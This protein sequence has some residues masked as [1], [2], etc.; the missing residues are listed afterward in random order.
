MIVRQVNIG[1]VL[2]RDPN[3]IKIRVQLADALSWEKKYDE[4]V[5]EYKKIFRVRSREY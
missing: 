3:N 5:G 2:K 1:D 4:S